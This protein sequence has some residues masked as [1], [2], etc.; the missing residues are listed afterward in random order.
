MSESP[1]R[2]SEAQVRRL[3]KYLANRMEAS[4]QRAFED[5]ILGDPMLS[6]ALYAEVNL[7][8]SLHE[9]AAAPSRHII[10]HRMAASIPRPARRARPW[11]AAGWLRL[12][13]P[14]AAVIAIVVVT[15]RLRREV[16][17]GAGPSTSSRERTP[18]RLRS[19][20]LR[21]PIASIRGLAPSG[22]LT[23][24]PRSFVWTRDPLATGYRLEIFD[25]YGSR[26]FD[27]VSSDTTYSAAAVPI[28]WTAVTSGSWRVTPLTQTGE[29]DPS[30][31]ISFRTEGR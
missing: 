4:E 31:S 12:A 6:E 16:F 22:D 9:A 3:G 21:A 7:D 19:G 20:T 25:T 11:W 26:I 23:E 18:R 14:L 1:D 10:S 15:P 24:P 2:L 17:P 28:S 29:G 13:L 5:E 30:P 27:A 8:A